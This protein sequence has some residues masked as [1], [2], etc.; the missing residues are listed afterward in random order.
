MKSA[1]VFRARGHP[2]ITARHPTT[3]MITKDEGVGPNGDCIVA[4]GAGKGARDLSGTIKRAIRAGS[5]VR[6]TLRVGDAVE[7][8]QGFG[9]PGLAQESP[10][11]IVLR[12]SRFTCGRTVAIEADKAAG[13]LSRDFVSLLLRPDVEIQ[14]SIEVL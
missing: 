10:T 4:V 14:V 7:V 12:K 9:D 6:V 13:D 3:L 8:I 5:R 1:E 11:D 2:Q